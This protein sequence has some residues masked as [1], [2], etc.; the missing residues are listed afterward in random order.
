[1]NREDL[2]AGKL[3]HGNPRG[4]PNTAPRCGARNR[5]GG[6]CRAP[7]MA[8]GRCRSH[9]GTST[10]PRTEAGLAA[11]RAARTVHGY[12]GA[13]GRVFRRT[14]AFLLAEGKRLRLMGP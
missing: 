7:A 8:N 9:G 6:A 4:D 5:A 13:D 12:Y 11:L 3:R 1:M 2:P 10:G 14:V